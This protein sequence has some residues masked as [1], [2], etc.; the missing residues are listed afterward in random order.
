M[1]WSSGNRPVL[2]P[3]THFTP[4]H[5]HALWSQVVRKWAH[6]LRV[7]TH[8]VI[9]LSHSVRQMTHAVIEWAYSIRFWHRPRI[10]HPF[11]TILHPLFRRGCHNS[12]EI[13][14]TFPK[15]KSNTSSSS[16]GMRFM[17]HNWSAT[18]QYLHPQRIA[19]IRCYSVL[20]GDRIR[21]CGSRRNDTDQC[22]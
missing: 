15:H 14:I 17:S 1:G 18:K 19:E 4:T 5:A 20:W 16:S 22:L 11:Y 3:P 8:L 6:L 7:L 10:L 2:G 9:A 21:L 12:C 13:S